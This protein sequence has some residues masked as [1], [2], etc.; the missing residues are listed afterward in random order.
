ME[1]S[2]GQHSLDEHGG[3]RNY[4]IVCKPVFSQGCT[5]NTCLSSVPLWTGLGPKI[6]V[7]SY[8]RDFFF[9][10]LMNAWFEIVS[11]DLW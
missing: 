1:P 6:R 3:M 4:S 8:L 5:V 10:G 7:A 11:L 9:S 2:K